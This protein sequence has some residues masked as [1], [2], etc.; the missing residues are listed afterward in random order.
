MEDSIGWNGRIRKRWCW[1]D[2]RSGR[3]GSLGLCDH[4]EG[5]CNDRALQVKRVD[6]GWRCGFRT[7]STGA[8]RD[9]EYQ[10]ENRKRFHVDISLLFSFVSKIVIALGNTI[11]DGSPLIILG[12]VRIDFTPLGAS[13][14]HK[15]SI[16]NLQGNPD[17]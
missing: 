13:Q 17:S 2:R 16:S 10:N 8:Q 14:M 4:R 15:G 12:T 5:C 7:T 1:R 3:D 9:H 6:G 11:Y